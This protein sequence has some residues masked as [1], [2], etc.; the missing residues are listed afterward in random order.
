MPGPAVFFLNVLTPT[1]VLLT[2]QE[3]SDSMPGS[4]MLLLTVLL[5]WCCWLDR[6]WMISCQVQLFSSYYPY[7]HPGFVCL[8][9]SEWFHARPLSCVSS[10]SLPSGSGLLVYH[11][12]LCVI[13]F[14]FSCHYPYS[15]FGLVGLTASKWFHA[16]FNYHDVPSHRLFS[17]PWFWSSCLDSQESV[18]TC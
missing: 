7:S 10:H 1:L 5:L 2:W 11:H 18:I 14:K 16:K 15:H 17:L 9:G 3:V 8:T 4:A 13:L 12:R 6:K